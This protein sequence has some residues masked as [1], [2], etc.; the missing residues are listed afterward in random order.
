MRSQGD[1]DDAALRLDIDA[2]RAEALGLSLSDVN[3]MLATIFSGREVN[4]FVLG[5]TLRPVIVQAGA[6]FRMQ[7]DDLESWYARNSAAE[8]V[9][10]IAFMSTLLVPTGA[11]ATLEANGNLVLELPA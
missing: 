11:V 8:M 4:D 1:E 6:P 3:G 10:F 2:Q 9:P 5:A 7:P